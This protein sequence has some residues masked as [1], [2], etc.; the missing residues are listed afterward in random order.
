MLRM[1]WHTTSLPSV[2]SAPS[3]SKTLHRKM[4]TGRPN[5]SLPRMA[6]TACSKTFF[7]R[8]VEPASSSAVQ[9]LCFSS[10]P[11]SPR[12]E[13][14]RLSIS[15]ASGTSPRQARR[16]RRSS[17]GCRAISVPGPV[18]SRSR[19]RS[20]RA[21]RIS[22]GSTDFSTMVHSL[23]SSSVQVNVPGSSFLTSSATSSST[24]RSLGLGISRGEGFGGISS[25]SSAS[26]RA[27][28]GRGTTGTGTGGSSSQISLSLRLGERGRATKAKTKAKTANVQGNTAWA[29]FILLSRKVQ[30]MAP[31]PT[32][33]AK[34]LA[35]VAA[36]ASS[37]G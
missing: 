23:S 3:M 7:A 35:M 19:C 10:I 13:I 25:E 36:Q 21:S 12:Q 16:N 17:R 28:T 30:A 27:G 5:L 29:L 22:V 33:I 9:D 11:R 14:E 6:W 8:G 32:R 37:K 31:E 15:A 26:E 1:I 34:I 4:Y 24:L 20:Q 2:F 18:M